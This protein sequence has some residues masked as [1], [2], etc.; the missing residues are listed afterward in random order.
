MVMD[1]AKKVKVEVQSRQFE[2]DFT[3]FTMKDP[4]MLEETK[5]LELLNR[6]KAMIE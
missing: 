5:R 6:V 1:E 4:R 2:K 3:D